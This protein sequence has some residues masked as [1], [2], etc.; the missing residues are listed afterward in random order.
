[1]ALSL[2]ADQESQAGL[3]CAGD[4]ATP[5]HLIGTPVTIG[6]ITYYEC[7]ANQ[8]TSS[9]I[10]LPAPGTG[11]ND[12]SP[13]RIASRNLFDAVIGMDNIFHGDRYRWSGQVMAINFTNKYALYNFLSTFSGT[14]F[15][16]PRAIT[17]QIAFHF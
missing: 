3:A 2:T 8:L 15:V 7:Q 6:G 12:K 10:Q 17:G 1:V 13:P 5:T 9:Q 14:H 4:R 16:T 11:N